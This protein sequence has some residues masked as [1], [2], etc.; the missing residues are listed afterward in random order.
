MTADEFEARVARL[1]EHI[2]SESAEDTLR[3]A[4]EYLANGNKL[5]AASCLWRA[6]LIYSR[7]RLEDV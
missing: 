5:L 2:V 7:E 1:E 3:K 6:K 4:E